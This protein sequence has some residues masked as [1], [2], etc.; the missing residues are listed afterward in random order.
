MSGKT[1][2]VVVT[3]ADRKRL[4]WDDPERGD[5]TWFSFFSAELTPTAGLCAGLAEFGRNG[6]LAPHRRPQ[7]EIYFVQQ[8]SGALTVDGVETALKPGMSVYIPGDAEH[9]VRNLSN[10]TLKIFYVFPTD[11][12]SDVIYRF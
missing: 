12:S 3:A 1:E 9:S 4:Q 11:R 7:A 2:A 6:S 10:E 5:V 8:G